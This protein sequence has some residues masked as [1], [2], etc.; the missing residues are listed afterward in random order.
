MIVAAAREAGEPEGLVVRDSRHG[1]GVLPL[2][3]DIRCEDLSFVEC[4][5]TAWL[6]ACTWMPGDG[7]RLLLFDLDAG[8]DPV[9]LR[10]LH[11]EARYTDPLA[12]RGRRKVKGGACPAK[13]NVPSNRRTRRLRSQA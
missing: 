13:W 10:S 6:V 9:E 7:A 4:G 3:G 1:R 5:G 8:S 11:G 2:R 12:P